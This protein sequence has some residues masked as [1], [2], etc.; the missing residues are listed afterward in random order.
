MVEPATAVLSCA[1]FVCLWRLCL[2]EDSP[3]DTTQHDATLTSV[4]AR[5]DELERENAHLQA[6]VAVLEE[7]SA[8]GEPRMVPG[9]AAGP[10]ELAGRTSRRRMLGSALGVAAATVG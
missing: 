4:L 1:G 5:L 6:K 2:G 9:Q 8:P 3:M 7:R 10:K